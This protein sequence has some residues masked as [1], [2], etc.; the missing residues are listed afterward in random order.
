MIFLAPLAVAAVAAAPI[1]VVLKTEDGVALA[2]TYHESAGVPGAVLVLMP[3][4]GGARKDWE[5]SAVKAAASGIAV[6]LLDPRGHG[7]SANPYGQGPGDWDKA[8]WRE[9]DR[10]P[11]AAVAWLE[12][13]GFSPSSIFLGGASIGASLAF[14]RAAS[15]PRL[16][17][18]AL[19]SP[20][21]N[22]KRVPVSEF[23][24]AYGRRPLFVTS[25]ADDPDFDAIAGRLASSVAGPVKRLRLSVGGHGT[26]ILSR[27]VSGPALTAGL[28]QWMAK[29]ARSAP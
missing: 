9:V 12:G 11:A 15:D 21:D 16:G 24:A 29:T 27:P 19:I 23:V 1:E 3:M 8:R 5:P 13:R 7:D 26:D 22:P 20:G 2:A 4:L 17:G 18:A 10:D 25:A 6:L 28:I 14:R